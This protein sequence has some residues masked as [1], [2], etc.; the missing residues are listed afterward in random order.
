MSIN[1]SPAMSLRAAVLVAMIS[2][3]LPALAHA[4]PQVMED[5]PF[6]QEVINPCVAE[7]VFVEGRLTVFTYQRSDA[8]GGQHVTVRIITKGKAIGVSS[9]FEPAKEYV[10]NSESIFEINIPS[11]GTVEETGVLNQVLVRKSESDTPLEPLAT[12]EDFMLKQ[13]AHM[14]F[15]N[16]VFRVIFDKGH[17]RC[18]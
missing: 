4:Q 8:S 5:L 3:F 9:P 2:V 14:T 13:T 17:T 6:A 18:M 12:G 15:S 11:S 16:G 7:P 10:Y 1:G